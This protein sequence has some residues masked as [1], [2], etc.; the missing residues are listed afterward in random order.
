MP[1]L[2]LQL[3][4]GWVVSGSHVCHSGLRFLRSGLHSYSLR[5]PVCWQSTEVSI[6]ENREYN[7]KIMGPRLSCEISLPPICTTSLG[8]H[9]NMLLMLIEFGALYIF[10]L[11]HFGS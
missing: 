6:A 7:G 8:L 9:G 1:P 5:S 4:D 11:V 10:G 2:S 3:G